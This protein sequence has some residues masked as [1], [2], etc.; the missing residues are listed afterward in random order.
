MVNHFLKNNLIT[1][2]VGLTHSLKNLIWWNTVDIDSFFPK[3]FDLTEGLEME[4]FKCEFRFLKAENILKLYF[5]EK[6]VRSIEMLNVAL[7]CCEKRLKDVDDQLDDPKV[8]LM[9]TD[10]EWEVINK[11]KQQLSVLQ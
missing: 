9:V 3:S 4:D 7:H 11:E 5:K 2:K 10:K 6:K 8:E 1:T